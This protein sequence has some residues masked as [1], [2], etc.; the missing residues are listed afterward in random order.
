MKKALWKVRAFFMEAGFVLTH[1]IGYHFVSGFY[2][3]KDIDARQIVEAVT[4]AR[5]ASLGRV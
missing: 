3:P 1:P 2:V 5:A 4:K